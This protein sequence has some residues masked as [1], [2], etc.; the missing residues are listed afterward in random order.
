MKRG[1]GHVPVLAAW[2][3]IAALAPSADAAPRHA[4]GRALE[5]SHAAAASA[6]A[7]ARALRAGHGVVTGR[8]LTPALAELSARYEALDPAER[9]EA[10]RLL[11]VRP[12]GRAIAEVHGYTVP[13]HA[14]FCTANFCMHWVTTTDDAPDLTDGDA[15][16][17][18]DVVEDMAAEFTTARTARTSRSAGRTR[19]PTARAGGTPAGRRVPRRA[20]GR[21]PARLRGDRPGAGRRAPQV[22]LHGHGRRTTPARPTGHR[23]AGDAAH[24]YNHVLQFGYDAAQDT[25]MAES[26]A[27]WME[28]RVHDTADR[29]L[30]FI[31]SW[32]TL[33]QIPLAKTFATKHYG[34][35]VWN[36]WLDAR[37]GPDLIRAAWEGS[38]GP[39]PQSLRPARTTPR[40]QPAATTGFAA[41]FV[42]FAA[43]RGGVA[44]RVGLPGGRRVR[45][46]AAPRE[47]PGGRHAVS[48]AL[49]HTVYALYT[50]PQPAGGWPAVLRLDGE[51]PAGVT[52]GLALVARTGGDPLTG[53]VTKVVQQAARRRRRVHPAPEPRRLRAHHGRAGKRRHRTRPRSR[54]G[55]VFSAD[56]SP[57]PPPRLERRRLG[58]A[59]E[60]GCATAS[61]VA[62]DG[63]QL[64]AATARGA[65]RRRG[66]CPAVAALRLRRG[67]LRGHRW[68]DRRALHGDRADIGNDACVA[69]VEESPLRRAGATAS[70]AVNGRAITATGRLGADHADRRWQRCASG[71]DGRAARPAIQPRLA[72][73]TV[74]AT[75]RTIRRDLKSVTK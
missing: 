1:L 20:G 31:P 73:R 49:D 38:A 36:M 45:G 25:W 22:R 74:R 12:T 40:S 11:A 48:P 57:S 27:V 63:S 58:G 10:D 59:R 41:S 72:G 21:R 9:R 7:R 44:H 19:S 33:D 69:A 51:L 60:H 32:A 52:G 65:A 43:G 70:N 46:R 23:D 68:G 3:L 37:Y 14:P 18:P 6:L 55:L 5:R 62:R 26:T 71:S 42:S 75:G 34:S 67:R 50:I 56:A 53:T 4:K 8:E 13:E 54:R 2:M 61:G 64:T 30:G 15:D 66:V 39:S 47:P 24:E 29:Y 28:D 17:V 35:A 16:D